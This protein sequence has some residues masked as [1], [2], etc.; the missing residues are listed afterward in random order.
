MP[1]GKPPSN[2]CAVRWPL[3]DRAVPKTTDGFPECR[4]LPAGRFDCHA[5]HGQVDSDGGPVVQL[6][7]RSNDGTG[8]KRA[9]HF[10]HE[11]ENLRPIRWR[12]SEHLDSH[13]LTARTSLPG[14]RSLCGLQDVICSLRH[15]APKRLQS[16]ALHS[17]PLAC[18]NLVQRGK[19]SD[20]SDAPR[21]VE[22]ACFVERVVAS[23]L[24]RGADQ[25][26]GEGL[27]KYILKPRC[28]RRI[29]LGH[30]VHQAGP[31][32]RRAGERMRTCSGASLRS[33]LVDLRPSNA[34]DASGGLDIP[35]GHWP[36]RADMHR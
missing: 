17:L 29:L 21:S 30:R 13:R 7:Q 32:S 28:S 4:R 5:T 6:L 36:A 12:E 10:L 34:P 27:E 22:P 1:H 20:I 9:T 15:I 16:G 8:R 19:S 2:V 26:G 24:D 31:R 14:C 35:V 18:H 3:S 11:K 25:P 23:L 33:K